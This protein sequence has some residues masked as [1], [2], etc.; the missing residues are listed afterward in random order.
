MPAGTKAVRITLENSPGSP[1]PNGPD[2]LRNADTLHT[3]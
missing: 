3:L 2:V 1:A